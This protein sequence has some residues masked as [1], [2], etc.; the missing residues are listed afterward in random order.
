[1][2]ERPLLHAGGH[3]ERLDFAVANGKVVQLAQ[4]WSFQV[5]DQAALAEQIKAWAWTIQ[6]VQHEGGTIEPAAGNTLEV[7]SDVNVAVVYVSPSAGQNAPALQDAHAVFAT[8][9]ATNLELHGA[10]QVAATAAELLA[11]SAD[12]AV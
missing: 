2:F 12:R 9:H 11:A 6:A 3:R 4:T 8:L 10:E 7:P 1:V 5:A